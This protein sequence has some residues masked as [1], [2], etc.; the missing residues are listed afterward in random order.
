MA[1]VPVAARLVRLMSRAETCVTLTP[2]I[3][4]SSSAKFADGADSI[5]C[6]VM[7]LIVAGASMSFS[8]VFDALT[9]TVFE[10]RRLRLLFGR[11]LVGRPG[12]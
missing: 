6:D 7:T 4:R 8:S 2:G 3:D 10:R 11:L 1:S 9:T 12:S 5:A